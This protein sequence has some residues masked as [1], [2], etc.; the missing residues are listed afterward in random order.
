MLAAGLVASACTA[1]EPSASIPPTAT[2]GTPSATAAATTGW[3]SPTDTPTTLASDLAAPW[4]VVPLDG[5]GALISERGD[6]T[7]LELTA[8]GELR[9]VGTVAGVVSGGESGLHGLAVW[10]DAGERWLYA[11]HGA[12]QDNRVVRMPLLGDPGAL[13]LGEPEVIL[14]GIARASNHDGG[15]LAFG[16]DGY[17]YVTTGDAG[18]RPSAQDEASLNGKILR[19]TPEGDPAPGNP[20]GTA[21]YTLGHRNVQGI[22]WT[23]DGTMWASEFGQDTFD[24]LNRIV[25]GG[26][27]GWPTHEGVAHDDAYIDPVA[28]WATDDASP[29]GIAAVGD[30]VFLASLRGER[31]W[32]V[33]TADGKLAA[34]PVASLVGE[35][36]RLRDVVAAPDGS[37]WILTNNT[38]G[39]GTPRPGDD[40]L[41]RLEVARHE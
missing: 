37:L 9:T 7:V 24:E 39:R 12:S 26:D 8:T 40:L 15:R 36:G 3:W 25:P 29:S 17:L 20:F 27:Y 18:I 35:Q 14:T 38:D 21:V 28:T 32:T 33:D 4:S 16:P 10:S 2:T 41:L 30:T 34:D 23:G 31:L 19:I 11:Y 5:G 22:A 6:G 13:S 1:A